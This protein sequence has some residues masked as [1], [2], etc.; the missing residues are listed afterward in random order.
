MCS[1]AGNLPS[2]HPLAGAN[3]MRPAPAAA[4]ADCGHCQAANPGVSPGTANAA[5]C[6]AAVSAHPQRFIAPARAAYMIKG[7]SEFQPMQTI[8]ADLLH[9]V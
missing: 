9:D 2:N 6:C 7:I 1:S 3:F 5:A 8:R 4:G